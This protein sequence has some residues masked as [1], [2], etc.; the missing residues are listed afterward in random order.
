MI[1]PAAPATLDADGV[2]L[3]QVLSNLLNNA[4]RYTEEGGRIWLCARAE[5]ARA[6][7][8]VRDTGVGI[9]EPMLDGVF[10]LFHASQRL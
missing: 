8:S 7:V 9:P 2:R 3:T 10:D 6:V 5:G 1:N 4:A